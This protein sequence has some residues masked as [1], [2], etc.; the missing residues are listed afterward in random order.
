MGV[1]EVCTDINATAVSCSYSQHKGN[2]RLIDTAQERGREGEDYI[3]FFLSLTCFN[4]T[5]TIF[6]IGMLHNINFMLT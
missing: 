2:I 4:K 1:V 5:F 3:T 6:R